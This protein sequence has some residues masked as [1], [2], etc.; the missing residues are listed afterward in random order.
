MEIHEERPRT[1]AE[2][3][4]VHNSSPENSP[5]RMD[6]SVELNNG[7]GKSDHQQFCLRWNNHQVS[8]EKSVKFSIP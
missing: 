1:P 7:S 5:P 4:V 8:F 3:K 2:N 6:T